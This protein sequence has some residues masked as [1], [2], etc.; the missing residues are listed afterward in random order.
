MKKLLLTL[1]T[2][3]IFTA[4]Q[5][6]AA[7]DRLTMGDIRS[8][9][10]QANVSLNSPDVRDGEEFLERV[11]FDSAH[12]SNRVTL[13]QQGQ[14]G[15]QDVWYESSLYPDT[16]Y[17]YPYAVYSPFYRTTGWQYL[18]KAE[19]IAMFKNKRRAIAG[20]ESLLTITGVNLPTYSDSA[21]VDIDL[22]EYSLGY[23][24]AGYPTLTGKIQ[25]AHAACKMYLTKVGYSVRLNRMDCNT[26]SSLA[27]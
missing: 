10:E 5:A 8:F 6:Q 26:N 21:V 2:M 11:T 27:L 18:G 4:P 19:N 16:Y 14:V 22:K 13:Y 24:P 7:E 12:F 15:V 23:R 20:Y 3:A 9:V 25:H 1:A 17:R